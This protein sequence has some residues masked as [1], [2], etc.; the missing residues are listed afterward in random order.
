MWQC[1]LFLAEAC[2]Q[3]VPYVGGAPTS[4][5]GVHYLE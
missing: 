5:P 1:F 3:S 4:G 2:S